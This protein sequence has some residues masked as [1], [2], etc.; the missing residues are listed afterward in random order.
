VT[1]TVSAEELRLF[2]R[3]VRGALDSFRYQGAPEA[4]QPTEWHQAKQLWALYQRL[5]LAFKVAGRRRKP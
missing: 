3:D 5:A 4:D 2:K 1:I